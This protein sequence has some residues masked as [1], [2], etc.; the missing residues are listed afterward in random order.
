MPASLL[1]DKPEAVQMLHS[2]TFWPV[3]VQWDSVS[4]DPSAE[5]DE[6]RLTTDFQESFLELVLFS[7][8]L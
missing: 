7:S 4:S 2:L 5:E 6:V 1:L 3:A 8:L